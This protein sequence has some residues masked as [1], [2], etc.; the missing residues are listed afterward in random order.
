MS[1]PSNENE[2]YL[3]CL[4]TAFKQQRLKAWQPLLTPKT[5][6]P[7]FLGIAALFIPVGIGLLVAS[8]QVYFIL[9]FCLLKL[10]SVNN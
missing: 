1:L 7:T 6:I 4:D 3:K 5:V 10:A 2:K 9:Q 8:N